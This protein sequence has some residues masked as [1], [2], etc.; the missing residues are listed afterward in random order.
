MV[1]SRGP[2]DTV[3]ESQVLDIIKAWE[4]YGDVSL[5]YRSRSEKKV[6]V[7]NINIQQISHFAPEFGEFP[8]S[9]ER[10]LNKQWSLTSGYDLIHCRGAVSAW[11]VL[12]SLNQKQRKTVK[13]VYDCRGI[14]VEE[15]EGMWNS[16]WKRKLLPFK[17]R[18]MRDIESFV[19]KEV[20]ILTTVSDG[21]SDYLEHHYGRRADLIIRPIVNAEKFYYSQADRDAIRAKLNIPN[22]GVLFIFVGGGA[23]WQNLDFLQNWW[24]SCK[25]SNFT[26]LI[27]SH[28]PEAYTQWVNEISV[29]N[30]GKIII[31]SVSHHEV[32]SYMSAAD[33]G[34]LFR[35]DSLVNKVASPVKLSEYLCT[36]LQVLTN[37]SIYGKIQPDDIRV[38]DL[39][40]PDI[41][42]NYPLRDSSTRETR[43]VI[44]LSRFSANT[45]VKDVFTFMKNCRDL[46]E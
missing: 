7:D 30:I 4:K 2:E 5:L 13:I 8:L 46:C 44:N 20:D 9:V 32:S 10:Y 37:L 14:V 38:I 34:V 25:R 21:L 42:E 41:G 40:N 27:L 22:D 15:M 3:F 11:Q 39:L 6:K 43:S 23:Y 19:V 24:A 45:A 26:L 28:T 1:S 16:S 17:M 29:D 35:D 12:Q 31:N 33:Y 18:A 36:G